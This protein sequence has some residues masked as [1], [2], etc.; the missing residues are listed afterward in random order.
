VYESTPWAPLDLVAVADLKRV[1]AKAGDLVSQLQEVHKA[2]IQN[3]QVIGEKIR[4][5]RRRGKL[6][7]LRKVT[8]YGLS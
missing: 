5:V 1:N 6:W 8:F 2:T 7:S 3:L 4:L